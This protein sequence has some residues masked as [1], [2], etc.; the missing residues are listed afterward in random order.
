[1]SESGRKNALQTKNKG[2]KIGMT[3]VQPPEVLYCFKNLLRL[4]DNWFGKEDVLKLFYEPSAK[5][6]TFSLSYRTCG[7]A[8]S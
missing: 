4:Q 5:T 3:T 8:G 2:K 1:M 6:F 7:R